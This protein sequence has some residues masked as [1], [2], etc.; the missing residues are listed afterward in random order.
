MNITECPRSIKL[1][2]TND[3][4]SAERIDNMLGKASY[5]QSSLRTKS[6][7]YKK[8]FQNELS[9]EEVELWK[10]ATDELAEL[11]RTA[12]RELVQ[13][14]TCKARDVFP[15]SD[16]FLRPTMA[17]LKVDAECAAGKNYM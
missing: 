6:L 9:E 2:C 16:I 11:R 14:S 10:I 13:G 3:K 17:D 5:K 7:S 8:P 4:C 1:F 15:Q 12:T